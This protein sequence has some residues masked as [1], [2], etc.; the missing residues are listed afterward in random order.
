MG[1]LDVG[2]YTAKVM[3]TTSDQVLAESSVEVRD[4]WF[5]R[6]EADARPDVMQRIAVM[7]GGEVIRD[8]Q[9]SSLVD[10]FEQRVLENSPAEVKRSS[11]W[12]RPLVL[13]SI[14]MIWFVSWVVRR[15]S[16]TI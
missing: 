7:S 14:L 3:D 8:D 12:D 4:P 16:G 11:I 13:L 1:T 5:E 10:R 9:I 15:R 2:Y 6:L